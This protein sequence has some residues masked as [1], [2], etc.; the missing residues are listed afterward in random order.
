MQTY[1]SFGELATANTTPLQSQ[2]SVFNDRTGG[3]DIELANQFTDFAQNLR[4]MRARVPWEILSQLEKL[5]NINL[6][7]V[8]DKLERFGKT[9]ELEYVVDDE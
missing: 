5:Q 2:M 1:N 4:N 6:E 3:P 7:R 8:A 9:L